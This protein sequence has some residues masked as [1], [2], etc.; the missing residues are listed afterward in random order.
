MKR[1]IVN[2]NGKRFEV[3]VEEVSKENKTDISEVKKETAVSS[4]DKDVKA[5]MPGTILDVKVNVGDK[6]KR[7][8][9]SLY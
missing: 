1:Y 3:E 2:I 7:E 9:Y 6:F 4:H 5:P 8:M